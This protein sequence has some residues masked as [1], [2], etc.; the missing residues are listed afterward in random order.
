MPVLQIAA[1]AAMIGAAAV[2]VAFVAGEAFLYSVRAR[3]MAR[4]AREPGLRAPGASR[5]AAAGVGGASSSTG[6]PV[7]SRLP[8]AAARRPPLPPT[9]PVADR[10]R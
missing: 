3:N 9:G 7:A 5:V 1:W 4:I 2:L 8:G 6:A 10:P